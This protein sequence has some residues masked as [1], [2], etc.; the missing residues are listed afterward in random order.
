MKLVRKIMKIA[1]KLCSFR[2]I[3]HYNGANSGKILT[4]GGAELRNKWCFCNFGDNFFRNGRIGNNAIGI[5]SQ[6]KPFAA[7]RVGSAVLGGGGNER[8]DAA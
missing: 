8:C 6:G 4:S 5:Q 1:L 3:L 7:R 2:L